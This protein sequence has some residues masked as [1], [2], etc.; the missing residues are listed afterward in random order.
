MAFLLMTSSWPLSVSSAPSGMSTGHA[1]AF[2]LVA[3]VIDR[4]V[5]VGADAIHLIDKRDARDI[6]FGR[7]PPDRLGL[8]LH[9]GDAVEHGDG[10]VEHAKG[11]LD[12]GREIHVA[13]SVDDVDAHA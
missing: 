5:E 8:R 7:L 9:A 6:V 11:A 10:A 3:H 1:L 2:E 12:L 4:V 13:G